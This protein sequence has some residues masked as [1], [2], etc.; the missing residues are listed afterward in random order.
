[1]TLEQAFSCGVHSVS[2]GAHS[3]VA[4][5]IFSC[6]HREVVVEALLCVSDTDSQHSLCAKG[7]RAENTVTRAVCR[8]LGGHRGRVARLILQDAEP[9]AG[10]R[11]Q[12]AE[13]RFRGSLMRNSP[14]D[15]NAQRSHGQGPV[16]DNRGLMW[17]AP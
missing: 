10:S 17:R 8:F 4:V 16:G 5:D 1:M 14:V 9:T 15:R 6:P 11:E 7:P 12:R 13:R 3:A 2:P